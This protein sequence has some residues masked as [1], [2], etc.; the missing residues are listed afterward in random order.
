MVLTNLSILNV[1]HYKGYTITKISNNC[2][3]IGESTKTMYSL[4]SAM[5]TV[6]MVVYWAIGNGNI[7]H[8]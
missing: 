8:R 3:K 4:A 7:Q 6:D 5:N 2:Y 1:I